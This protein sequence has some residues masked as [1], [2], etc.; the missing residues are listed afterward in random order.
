M[1]TEIKKEKK[2]FDGKPVAK[3]SKPGGVP[4]KDANTKQRKNAPGAG[5]PLKYTDEWIDNE[6]DILLEWIKKDEG[7]YIGSFAVE[8]GYCRQNLSEFAQKS[9]KFSDAMERARLWQEDK[10]IRNGLTK[11]WDGAHVRYV[12]ARVCGD[13]WKASYDKEDSDRDVTL[14]VTIKKIG[15][16]QS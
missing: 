11:E 8:R 12:M 4:Y 16:S 2:K 15:K 14:N 6:A 5:R 1:P 9:S 7:V 3:K 10:F 13:I